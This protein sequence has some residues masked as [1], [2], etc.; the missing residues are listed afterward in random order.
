MLCVF[1]WPVFACQGFAADGEVQLIRSGRIDE[2]IRHLQERVKSNPTDAE[3]LNLLARA[4]YSIEHWDDAIA[5]N[6]RALEIAA[7]QQRVP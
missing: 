3:S 1:F 5:T 7:Q 2:A 6:Q 4:Y